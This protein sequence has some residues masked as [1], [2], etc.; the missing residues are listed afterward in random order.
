MRHDCS[1]RWLGPDVR[2]GHNHFAVH[3]W[4]PPQKTYTYDRL[5][6]PVLPDG[7]L[8]QYNQSLFKG[9]VSQWVTAVGSWARFDSPH[10]DAN[11][12]VPSALSGVLTSLGQTALYLSPAIFGF[13]LAEPNDSGARGCAAERPRRLPNT[14]H[15]SAPR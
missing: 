11:D 9:G 13:V 12:R 8:H 2:R 15:S 3:L 10:K 14:A 5:L 6:R 4:N 1:R 7:T